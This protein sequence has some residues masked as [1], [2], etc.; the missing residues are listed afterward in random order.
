MA[1]VGI[2]LF[3]DHHF[4]IVRNHFSFTELLRTSFKGIDK[5]ISYRHV[6]SK[7][8]SSMCKLYPYKLDE[9]K[10]FAKDNDK[11]IYVIGLGASDYNSGYNYKMFSSHIE[12]L[13]KEIELISDKPYQI[14][15]L[16]LNILNNLKGNF[17]SNYIKMSQIIKNMAIKNDCIL[18]ES[19]V[20][21]LFLNNGDYVISTKTLMSIFE[22]LEN[23]VTNILTLE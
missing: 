14:V 21:F 12:G 5:T 20:R 1:E 8:I 11:N 4:G 9:L 2:T 7:N 17:S 23:I 18:S 6:I 22:S 10:Y 3:L 16:H 15:F 13:I 19:D